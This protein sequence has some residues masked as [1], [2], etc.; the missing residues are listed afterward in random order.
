VTLRA[1][2]T[3]PPA[4]L[5]VP[6]LPAAEAPPTLQAAKVVYGGRSLASSR[7]WRRDL[8]AGHVV[9]GP[10]VIQ[11]YSATTWVPPDWRAEVD[12]WGCLHLLRT[13]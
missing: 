8:A 6:E 11:E 13:R 3:A 9:E 12:R 7:V 5:E 4:T 10:S 2:V 1:V